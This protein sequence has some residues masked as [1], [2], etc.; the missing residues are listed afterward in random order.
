MIEF[1]WDEQKNISNRLKHRLSFEEAAR[2]FFDPFCLRRQDRF[3]NG[4]ERW[5]AIGEV[6]GVTLLL[7]AHTQRDVE[8]GEII[9]IISARR[10]T[11]AER[12]CYEFG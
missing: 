11:K 5:Q 8:G 7:V 3:E 12:R 2:V 6:N 1:E 9:C 4:E 10:A